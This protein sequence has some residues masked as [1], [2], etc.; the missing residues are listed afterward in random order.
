MKFWK[1]ERG[2]EYPISIIVFQKLILLLFYFNTFV[3]VNINYS[4]NWQQG[5]YSL[6]IHELLN[7]QTEVNENLDGFLL[8]VNMST[9]KLSFLVCKALTWTF[10]SLVT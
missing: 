9:V 3:W 6:N 5:Y 8:A 7:V 1:D 10:L 2:D 4:G